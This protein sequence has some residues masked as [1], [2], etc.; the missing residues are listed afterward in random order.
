MLLGV[1]V[2]GILS[3]MWGV[4]VLYFIIGLIICVIFLIGILFLYFKFLDEVIEEK[5]V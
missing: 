4:R 2:G 5:I 3:E 1:L